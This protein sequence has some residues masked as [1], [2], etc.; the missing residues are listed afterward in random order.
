MK[1][2][3]ITTQMLIVCYGNKYQAARQS[4]EKNESHLSHGN[5]EI[6]GK[7]ST[8]L[9]NKENNNYTAYQSNVPE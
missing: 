5:A 1:G 6:S 9:Y 4:A 2:K 7:D 8:Q 3:Y